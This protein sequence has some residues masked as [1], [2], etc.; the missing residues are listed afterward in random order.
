M[1]IIQI[2]FYVIPCRKADRILYYNYT[3]DYI[4]RNVTREVTT[5]EY[6]CPPEVPDS[7]NW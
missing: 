5:R 3:V 1:H 7:H 6:K 4:E 2:S